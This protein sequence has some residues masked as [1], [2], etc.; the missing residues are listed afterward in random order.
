MGWLSNVSGTLY[1]Q[2]GSILVPAPPE[3]MLSISPGRIPPDATTTVT[4]LGLNTD[5]MD[6]PPTF[7]ATGAPTADGSWSIG[8]LTVITNVEA[9]QVVTTGATRGT[10][11]WTD[12]TTS[13]TTQ[14]IVA[15]RSPRMVWGR[16]L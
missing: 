14:M 3:T 9:N 12:S 11:T 6:T 13:D 4:F 1:G 16:R 7:T 8:T 15:P 5:W 10:V 2:F